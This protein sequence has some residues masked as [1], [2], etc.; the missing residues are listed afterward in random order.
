MRE[1][2]FD[3]LGLSLSTATINQCVDEAGRALEPVLEA[4]IHAA[5]RDAEVLYADETSA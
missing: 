2:L 1:F 3:W 4:E 5:V